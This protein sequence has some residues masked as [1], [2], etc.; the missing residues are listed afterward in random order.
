MNEELWDYRY[1]ELLKVQNKCLSNRKTAL[2]IT[3]SGCGAAFVGSI[4]GADT[5]AGAIIFSLGAVAVLTGGIWSVINEFKLI[6]NQKQLNEHLC[7]KFT[8]TSIAIT[9]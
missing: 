8:P 9:F 2:I 3:T 1:T 4:I 5:E 6:D 7:L